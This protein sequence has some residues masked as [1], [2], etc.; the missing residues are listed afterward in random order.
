MVNLSSRSN[1][2]LD[3]DRFFSLD[4]KPDRLPGRRL[5]DPAVFARLSE[6]VFALLVLLSMLLAIP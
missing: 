2:T 1:P 3:A 6:L 4:L 5:V